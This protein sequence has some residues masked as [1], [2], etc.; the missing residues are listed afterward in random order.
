[1]ADTS[2][3]APSPDSCHHLGCSDTYQSGWACQ[4]FY[5]CHNYASCCSG[6]FAHCI[7]SARNRF[8]VIPLNPSQTHSDFS[9]RC[10]G[11]GAI[12]A[13]EKLALQEV[14]A[15]SVFWSIILFV[16]TFILL[17]W[18]SFFLYSHCKKHRGHSSFQQ[19]GFILED[20]KLMMVLSYT[21]MS[22]YTL[23]LFS[24]LVCNGTLG[25]DYD[26]TKHDTYGNSQIVA[27]IF[28]AMGHTLFYA[29]FMLRLRHFIRKTTYNLSALFQILAFGLLIALWF[30][31][32]IV[33]I[34]TYCVLIPSI[35]LSLSHSHW[36]ELIRCP[37]PGMCSV[38]RR[39]P[40]QLPYR[41]HQ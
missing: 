33:M 13:Q 35:C 41:S 20:T 6:T 8:T 14:A 1:M 10:D 11:M 19:S 40:H 36:T 24:Y 31:T 16:I 32:A 15:F 2:S 23:S 9:P 28:W 17:C 34:G 3:T 30:V 37:L 4:C 21:A 25:V 5:G 27:I 26:N 7:P 18:A 38:D 22:F 12:E 39:V 29:V